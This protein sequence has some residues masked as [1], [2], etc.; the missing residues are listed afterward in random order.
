MNNV[1]GTLVFDGPFADLLAHAER[2]RK[3]RQ[4]KESEIF[5]VLERSQQPRDNVPQ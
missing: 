2:K 5:C 3:E 1:L 4:V